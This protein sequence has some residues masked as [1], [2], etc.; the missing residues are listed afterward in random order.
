MGRAGVCV[1][2]PDDG[3]SPRPPTGA[4]ERP[5]GPDRNDLYSF[6]SI[7]DAKAA[8]SLIDAWCPRLAT[9]DVNADATVRVTVLPHPEPAAQHTSGSPGDESTR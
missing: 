1:C 7:E 6:A 5:A 3:P 9:S 8:K 2:Q 4:A